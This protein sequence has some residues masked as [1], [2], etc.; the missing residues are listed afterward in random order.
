MS[1][2][3]RADISVIIVNYKVK[4]YVA[5]LLESVRKAAGDLHLEIFVVDNHSNDG[6]VAYLREKFPDIHLI[7][8][9][10][11][12]GFG[13]ANNQAIRK[14]KGKYTLII[15]PDTLVS[16]D[17]LTVM[18][19]HMDAHP[20]CGAAGCKI[21]NPDGSFA[22]ESRRSVPGIWSAACKVFGLNYIFPKSKV[23]G[24]YYL[25]WLD[26][27]T[28]SD[29]PVLSGSFMFWRTSLLK[30][31]D[32]FD[33]RFFMYGEDIDLCYRVQETDYHI[34]YVPETSIIHY[35]GESTQT[36][37][38]RYIRLFNKA[39]YQFFEKQYSSRYS[40]LFRILIFI[41]V[42]LKT[43]F[44][45]VS[46]KVKQSGMVLSD[47]LIL[48]LSLILAF[49]MRFGFQSEVIF[50]PE[51]LGFLWINL[52]LSVLYLFTAG[53]AGVF[54]D[55]ESLSSHLKAII[56]AYSA[57]VLITYFA[58]ELAFSRFILGFGFLFGVVGT[59]AFR[60]IRANIGRPASLSGRLRNSRVI[61]VADK[62]VGEELTARI[63]SRPDWKY[64]V[65]GLIL[66][67]ED[68][69]GKG[70]MGTLSQ[71]SDLALAYRA[72]EVFFALRSVTY[73]T[74]LNQIA[75]LQGKGIS[76]KL[77]P[78]SMDFIL[79]KSK[80]EYLE[81]IPLVEVDMSI[82]KPVNRFLKRSLDITLSLPLFLVGL[83]LTLPSIVW[84]R[85]KRASIGSYTFYKPLKKHVWKNR[86]Q[87]LGYVLS[88][89]MSLVGT[90]IGYGQSLKK[91]E[92]LT[93]PV[94]LAGDKIRSDEDKESFELYYQQNYSIW[95]DIDM[96]F[97]TLFSDYSV[98]NSLQDKQ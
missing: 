85:S 71:L 95:M 40:I 60:L 52:L 61:I 8:N 66:P 54:K 7:A 10:E 86:V 28:P 53:L 12:L 97:R 77:I 2:N 81:A 41:A 62:E 47:L 76:F 36:E 30:E 46:T 11:N 32:G 72:D 92:G 80:V 33:E 89:R 39:L 22:P 45:F 35:K 98:L 1:Q 19:Q 48:N 51:N 16:E 50:A 65:I 94:Q 84:S 56:F 91:T 88:G 49:G 14:A 6:S 68:S 78:D 96:L 70:I 27:D 90:E 58:R 26:E 63:H 18:K 23:F 24:Q 3:E 74:M 34:E 25:S 75:S 55:K 44:S 4:E 21:L 9:E 83:V 59:M 5:N 73:K 93:G 17:T 29:V 67:D 42:K 79:G 87:L 82:N 37:D 57:V 31:L 69:D 20:D 43:L 13:K 15:N 64:E 38:L